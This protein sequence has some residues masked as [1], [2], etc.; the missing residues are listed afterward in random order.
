MALTVLEEIATNAACNAVV[1]LIDVSTPGA[2]TICDGED[3]LATG[4]FAAEAFGAAA[5][6]VATK[7]TIDNLVAT[8]AGTA[9]NLKVY[10]GST[11][12]NLIMTIEVVEGVAPVAGKCVLTNTT[13][14]IGDVIPIASWTHTQPTAA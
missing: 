5:A 6:G 12:P 3:V 1:G 4:E 10:D 7:G 14:A 8:G 9:D 11:I 13:I 2:F